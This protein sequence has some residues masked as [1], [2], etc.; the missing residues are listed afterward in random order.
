VSRSPLRVVLDT[1]VVLSALVF[2]SETASRLRHAWQCGACRP[3]VST[4]T[5][6]ELLRVLA[7][8]KF[9]LSTDDQQELLADYLPFTTSV[10][11]PATP[12]AVPQCRDPH[13][14]IFLELAAAGRARLLV[15]GDRDLLALAGQTAFG[16]V[17]PADFLLRPGNIPRP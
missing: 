9:R 7:Y 11:I 3:L 17:T 5:V 15:S 13:D 2:R 6:R 12:P 10:R 4:A 8:P 14:S 16:I 1:N